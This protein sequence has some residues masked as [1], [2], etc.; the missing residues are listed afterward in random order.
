MSASRSPAEARPQDS[1]ASLPAAVQ[2]ASVQR[3]RG[4]HREQVVDRLAEETPVALLR[5]GEAHAVMLLTPL[6]LE[7]FALGFALTEGLVDAPRELVLVETR[8]LEDGVVLDLTI[9]TRRPPAAE[10]GRALPG[11]TGCGLCGKRLLEDALRV[12]ALL[13]DGPAIPARALCRAAAALAERQ[14]LSR[15]TG[16]LH[17]AAWATLAGE[18]VCVREDVGRHNALDKLVGARARGGFP[19]GFAVVT[20]R[21]SYEMVLKAAV[22]G[23][24]LLA[25]VSAPTARA[26]R[27]AASCNLTLA[28]FLRAGDF[29][30]YSHPSRVVTGEE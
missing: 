1:A 2:A 27:L 15:D 13:A 30:L 8:V 20:S 18:L 6:D 24:P 14:P 3:W 17:A 22:A 28:G 25:A 23:M 26:V 29:V 11:R 21:A 10:A 16:A 19:P 12:P 9:S 5:N 7:D 4:G